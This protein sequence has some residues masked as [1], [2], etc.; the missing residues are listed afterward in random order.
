MHILVI[1]S[2]AREHA[3]A[4]HLARSGHQVEAAPGNPGIARVARCHDAKLDDVGGLVALAQALAVDLVVVGP[5]A[6]LAG[7]LVDAL[8]DKGMLAFGP[9][10][11][12]TRLES[13]KVFAK[14]FMARH[15]IP[16]ARFKV[17]DTPPAAIEAARGFGWPVV[18]KA[19]GLAAGKGVLVAK[20]ESEARVFATS[21]LTDRRFGE[22]GARLVVEAFLPGEE[23]SVFFLSDGTRVRAFP[24]AR[25]AKRL[26]DGDEGPNTGGMGAFAPASL[27]RGILAWIEREVADRTVAG[28]AAEGTPFRGLLYVGLML[29]PD[30]PRVLEFNAR[31]G[32]PETQALLPL[33]RSDLG[34]LFA[35]CARGQLRSALE[36]APGGAV[37][38]VLAAAG[39]PDQPRLGD[40]IGG[41][42][43]WPEP[44]V[45]NAEGL[46][47]FHAGTRVE[48]DRLVSAG[49]RVLTVVA[50]RLNI[51]TARRA[52]YE[53]LARIKL[54]GGQAR[55]D[56]ALVRT[57][58]PTARG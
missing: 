31:F 5:E 41:L 23:A 3:L 13:S 32:D 27:D 51:V 21:C 48:G 53:G 17:V 40:A 52:A 18:L 16:S 36:C 10:R 39:Y 14:E 33:V 44:A 1:G 50:S 19:D 7:G 37:A 12:A 45:E 4:W 24:P 11:A 29:G 28:M 8:T 58:A 38:V 2:G 34:G 30:G 26:S 35:E 49:G 56:I 42:A 6:P 15:G 25:D 57:P 47:C 55:R 20:D 46:W 43:D 9:T 22:S 54:E